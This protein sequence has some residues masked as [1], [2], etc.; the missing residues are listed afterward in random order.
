M[1]VPEWALQYR[2]PRTE[3]RLIKGICYKYQVQYVYNK[4]KKLISKITVRL[5]GKITES[6]GFI[7]SDKDLMR[8]KQNSYP[9]LI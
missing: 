3:I 8:Q 1:S 5:L 9:K 2:E 7:T 4:S 6:G